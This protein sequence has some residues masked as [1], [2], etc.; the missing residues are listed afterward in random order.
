MAFLL[1]LFIL[2]LISR[3][4]DQILKKKIIKASFRALHEIQTQQ[5]IVIIYKTIQYVWP[6]NQEN[7]RP[8]GQQM[9]IFI[10][11]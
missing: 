7:T 2:R 5:K 8:I 1:F 10:L 11:T 9:N 3:G 6:G 4:K